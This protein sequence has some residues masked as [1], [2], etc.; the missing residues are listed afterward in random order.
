ME[1]VLRVIFVTLGLDSILGDQGTCESPN[2]PCVG[3]ETCCEDATGWECCIT[4]TTFCVAPR[5]NFQTSTCCPRWTVGCQ[6]GSVGCCDPAR[7]WQYFQSTNEVGNTNHSFLRNPMKRYHSKAA[8]HLDLDYEIN[9]AGKVAYALFVSDGIFKDS[10]LSMTVELASG[11]VIA[12]KSVTGPVQDYNAKLFGSSTRLFSWDPAKVRFVFADADYAAKGPAF[13]LTIYSIDAA[14]GVS[15]SKAVS[16]CAGEPL[17]MAFDKSTQRLIVATQDKDSAFFCSVNPDTGVAEK[18]SKVARGS[19]ETSDTYYAAYM[20]YV[21]SGIAYRVGHRQVSFGTDPGMNAVTLATGVA[22]KWNAIAL[23]RNHSLPV[24]MQVH[25]DGG[26]VSLAPRGGTFALDVI[27][28]DATNNTVQVLKQL[29]NANVPSS[30]KTGA[31]GYV[32]DAIDGS[33]FAAMTVQ[34]GAK[35][36]LVSDKWKISTVDL[37]S[38]AVFESA[39]KPQPAITGAETVTLSGFGMPATTFK[40]T[41][42]IL[43]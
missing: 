14:T 38:G 9:A 6:V 37:H 28:W 15:T 36:P 21:S 34:K 5:G 8:Q 25:P 39:L 27:V 29:T 42:Q 16:G 26:F 30:P 2:P 31:L 4:Q 32:G 3:A 1:F 13:P 10:L 12:K 22:T 11:R 41:E 18:L 20:S 19:G 35:V 40:P 7:P 33:T 23:A 17:G 43:V 24:S